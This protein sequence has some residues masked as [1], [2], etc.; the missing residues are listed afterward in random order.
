MKDNQSALS[1]TDAER[2]Y[3]SNIDYFMKKERRD[4]VQLRRRGRDDSAGLKNPKEHT[5]V[6]HDETKL[7]QHQVGMPLLKSG[8]GYKPAVIA[9]LPKDLLARS[10]VKAIKLRGTMYKDHDLAKKKAAAALEQASKRTRTERTAEEW[11]L[12]VVAMR[13]RNDE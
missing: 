1:R 9:N 2:K 13:V 6:K 3:A 5:P 8:D 10:G 11:R 7:E 4:V 12:D